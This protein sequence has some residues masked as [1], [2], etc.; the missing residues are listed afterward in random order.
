M[1]HPIIT[2]QETSIL[3]DHEDRQGCLVFANAA[4]AAVLVR[5]D[6]PDHG[7]LVGS[8]FLETGYGPCDRKVDPFPSREA[9]LAWV[10]D[11]LSGRGAAASTSA[12]RTPPPHDQRR[13]AGAATAP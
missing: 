2:S 7:E 9:A 11:C 10:S 13:P 6:I 3:V 12:A 4:L 5:L 8:W 1:V